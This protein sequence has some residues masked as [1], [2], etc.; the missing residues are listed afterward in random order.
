MS[1]KYVYRI[2]IGK[3]AVEPASI[4]RVKALFR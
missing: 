2:T 4:G 3:I 1:P